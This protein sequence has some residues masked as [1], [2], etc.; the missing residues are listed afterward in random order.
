MIFR[1]LISWI[2]SRIILIAIILIAM[3][4]TTTMNDMTAIS[5]MTDSTDMSNITA[6]TLMTNM[7]AMTDMVAIT[8]TTGILISKSY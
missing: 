2:G 5:V 6:I 7:T 4:D 8:D 1:L 3:T